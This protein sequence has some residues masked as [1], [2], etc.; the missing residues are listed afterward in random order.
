M[1]KSA[2]CNSWEA[3]EKSRIYNWTEDAEVR[4]PADSEK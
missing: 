3:R 4:V 2:V 1:W